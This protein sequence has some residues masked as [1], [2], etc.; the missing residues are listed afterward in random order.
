[1]MFNV[2]FRENQC[3]KYHIFVYVQIK[4][5]LFMYNIFFYILGVIMP[6]FNYKFTVVCMSVKLGHS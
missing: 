1:M 2:R 4:V 5:H 3:R 6:W